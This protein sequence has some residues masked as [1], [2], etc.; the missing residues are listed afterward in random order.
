MTT[1]KLKENKKVFFKMHTK[2]IQ[3]KN[4]SK[5]NKQK[6]WKNIF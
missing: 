6:K 1:K 3:H 5:I 2:N 4:E